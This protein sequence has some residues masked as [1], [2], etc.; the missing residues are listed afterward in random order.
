LIFVLCE[1]NCGSGDLHSPS[2]LYKKNSEIIILYQ[3][4]DIY[5]GLQDTNVYI[6]TYGKIKLYIFLG[7]NDLVRCFHCGGGL[8]S[9]EAE[10]NP[11]V[12]HAH[13]FPQCVFLRQNKGEEFIQ[14]ISSM[15][16]QLAVEQQNQQ[17]YILLTK[18]K[19][20]NVVSVKYI[21]L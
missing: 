21:V 11:W 18:Q 12:E 5:R 9:W 19:S 8:T 14:I 20:M 13:W 1:K 4:V 2:P 17:V 15:V 16:D 3:R 7:T 6:T 10:D